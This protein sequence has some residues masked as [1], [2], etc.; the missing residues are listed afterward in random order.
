M[1]LFKNQSQT[2]NLKRVF[3][4]LI[5]DWVRSSA[6]S[7]CGASAV[8]S[9]QGKSQTSSQ[10]H[11]YHHNHA[12]IVTPHAAEEQ[13]GIYQKSPAYPTNLT[14]AVCSTGLSTR[15]GVESP[16]ISRQTSECREATSLNLSDDS[17]SP[18]HG[19]RH[20]RLSETHH[21][22]TTKARRG[23]RSGGDG[24]IGAG[25]P[26]QRRTPYYRRR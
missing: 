13:S 9:S 22:A 6:V 11:K 4:R 17:W 5:H 25:P 1:S 19:L 21:L 24:G 12:Q 26:H 2:G 3:V 15:S 14:V 16:T 10:V 7:P 8:V 18:H 20:G 23:R